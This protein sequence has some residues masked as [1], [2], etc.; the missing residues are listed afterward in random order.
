MEVTVQYRLSAAD[1]ASV[2]RTIGNDYVE[3]VVRP[4][5]RSALRDGAVSYVATDLYASRREEFVQKVRARI[6][7]AFRKRGIVLENVLLRDVELPQRVKEAINDKIAAEQESQKMVY[8]LTKEKQEA[9]RKRV[10][11]AGISDAQKIISSSLSNQYLQ[12]NYI[13]TLKSLAGS[14]NNTFVI[15][16]MDQKLTPMINVTRS[17][18]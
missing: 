3:K 5:I 1:A 10:E 13:Q 8:V 11:A 12:Y 17:G 9:E 16:P 6:D 7:T 18:K 4:E 15:T 14:N 2:Y